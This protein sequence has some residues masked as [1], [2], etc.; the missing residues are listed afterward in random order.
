VSACAR[1]TRSASSTGSN[2]ALEP[3]E[4]TT[5]SAR[6]WSIVIPNVSEPLPAEL[7]PSMPPIVARLLVDVSGPNI[8]PWAAAASLS[9][10]CT[11]P[12]STTAVRATGSISTI[13][14]MC[15]ERSSTRPGPTV[16]PARLVP[17]PRGTT[18]TPNSAA[19]RTVAAT[20]SWSRGKTTPRGVI[21]YMLASREN[22]W[23]V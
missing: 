23:R 2:R 8:S 9:W 19:V 7:L 14:F 15:R 10:S 5:S 12:T 3:S 16:C 21:E 4:S 20:S 18:G 13:R 11:T 22:R 17:A 1:R 6:M